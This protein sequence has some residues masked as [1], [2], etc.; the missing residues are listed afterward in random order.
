MNSFY[1]DH[2]L[3][4]SIAQER[5]NHR[6][7]IQLDRFQNPFSQLSSMVSKAV[8]FIQEKLR[9]PELLPTYCFEYAPNC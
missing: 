2:V 1:S 7:S 8:S 3:A 6:E 5:I 4:R 9:Q